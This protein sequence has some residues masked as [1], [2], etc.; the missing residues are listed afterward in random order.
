MNLLRQNDDKIW[1]CVSFVFTIKLG[2]SLKFGT[3]LIGKKG[4]LGNPSL[5]SKYGRQSNLQ[6][7]DKIGVSVRKGIR[8]QKKEA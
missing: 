6:S 1:E 2:I 5:V 8:Q 7:G 3:K 4:G